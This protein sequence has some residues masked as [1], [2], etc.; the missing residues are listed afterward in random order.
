MTDT[1]TMEAKGDSVQS[2]TEEIEMDLTGFDEETQK[3]IC[4]V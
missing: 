4:G 3:V 2:I 1:M